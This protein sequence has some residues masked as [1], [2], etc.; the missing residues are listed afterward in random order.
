MALVKANG[1][2]LKGETLSIRVQSPKPGKVEMWDDYGS[3]VERILTSDPRWHNW[4]GP[5]KDQIV[6]RRGS[7][8]FKMGAEKGAEVSVRFEGTGAIV[9]GPYL[10]T[11]G[12]ATIYLDGKLDGVVDLYPDEDEPKFGASI[13]YRFGSKNGPHTV[14]LVVNGEPGPGSKGQDVALEDIIVYR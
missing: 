13:W 8:S 5:W 4:K 11:G 14:R 2:S 3:P 9:S 6:Q 1:G 7:R 12:K 10:P